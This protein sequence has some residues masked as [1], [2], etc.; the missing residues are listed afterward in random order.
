[1]VESVFPRLEALLPK[2][3]KPI[4]YVGG[5]LNAVSKEWDAA[6]VRWVLMYPD[7]YEIDQLRVLV[8]EVVRAAG[9]RMVREVAKDKVL[10]TL[11]GLTD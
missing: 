7:A 9:R 6:A 10:D 3:N 8:A 5:E 2:V 11:K 1:M 4:Q